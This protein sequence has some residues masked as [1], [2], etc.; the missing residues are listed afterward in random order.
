MRAQARRR[1]R[2]LPHQRARRVR[3]RPSQGRL[4]GRRGGR[5]GQA[6][7]AHLRRGR[8]RRLHC[9]PGWYTV[10]SGT[11]RRRRMRRRGEDVLRQP[12]PQ[13]AFLTIFDNILERPLG[14]NLLWIFA[15]EM[16]RYMQA[17]GLDKPTSH[18]G[19]RE[20]QAERRGPSRR[21]PG[22]GRH[23]RGRRPGRARR[24]RGRCSVSTSLPSPTARWRS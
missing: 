4:P 18:P 3:R 21:A 6:V 12:H 2:R 1:R 24:S 11:R 19:G 13:G 10:A 9:D 20:E 16:Q 7:H 8:E 23:H 15:L 14:P 17:Y 22:S 5:V